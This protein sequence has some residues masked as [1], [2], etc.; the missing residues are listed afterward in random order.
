MMKDG[1]SIEKTES[2]DCRSQKAVVRDCG[3]QSLEEFPGAAGF[4]LLQTE[5]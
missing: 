1:G 2:Q 5:S 3:P 4:R